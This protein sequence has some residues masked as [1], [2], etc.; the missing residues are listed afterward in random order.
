[1]LPTPP[2]VTSTPAVAPAPVVTPT[3]AV[4]PTP[5]VGDPT[6]NTETVYNTGDTVIVNGVT[7]TAGWWTKGQEPG[8]TG[9]W[10]VWK[11]VK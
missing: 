10:G 2:V 1:M 4:T 3:P 5:V 11:E 6:W 7:Y 9:Q 8:T